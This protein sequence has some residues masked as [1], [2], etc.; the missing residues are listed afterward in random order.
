MVLNS[1]EISYQKK[2]ILEVMNKLSFATEKDFYKFFEELRYE[3]VTFSREDLKNLYTNYQKYIGFGSI[4]KE[5]EFP[6]YGEIRSIFTMEGFCAI[7]IFFTE[8]DKEI[9]KENDTT[10]S[11]L[12]YNWNFVDIIFKRDSTGMYVS[13]LSF[14]FSIIHK[15]RTITL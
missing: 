11:M 10:S 5:E 9:K 15:N 2:N 1:Y 12:S 7:G 3:R 13:E 14:P 4:P 6:I 8:I